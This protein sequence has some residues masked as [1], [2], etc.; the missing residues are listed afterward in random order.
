MTTKLLSRIRFASLLVIVCFAA[1]GTKADDRVAA[2]PIPV[3]HQITGLFSPD[4]EKDLREAIARLPGVTVTAIDFGNA[5][6][7]VQ[8]DPKKLFPDAKPEQI[9]EQFDN[10]LRSVSHSTFGVKPLRAIP[11]DKLQSIE[12]PAAGL[13]CKAC[14]LAAYEMI[15]KLDGVET[16]TAD[17]KAGRITALIDPSKTDR[18]KL[19]AVLKDRGV[20]L[21][22]R[23]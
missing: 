15:Y 23:K 19:E 2:S 20:S 7:T 4:R 5:E 17:F 18:S 21:V 22:P 8:Y 14:D 6:I 1:G 12:I 11:R 16:A 3:K 10:R 13:D 9:V